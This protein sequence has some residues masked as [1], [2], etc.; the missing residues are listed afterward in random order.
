MT[1]PPE[2]Q[3]EIRSI[4]RKEGTLLEQQATS[5]RIGIQSRSVKKNGKCICYIIVNQRRCQRKHIIFPQDLPLPTHCTS[6]GAL[7][8]T[9]QGSVVVQ[10]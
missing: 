5:I 10:D 8:I 1:S 9:Y 2:I 4:A 6:S 7:A 3:L